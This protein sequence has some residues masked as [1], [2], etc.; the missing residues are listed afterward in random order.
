MTSV[1]RNDCWDEVRSADDDETEGNR[2]H[3]IG[4]RVR[5]MFHVEVFLE[6][7]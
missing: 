2:E 7:A 6:I 1:E 3:V 4:D 5:Y